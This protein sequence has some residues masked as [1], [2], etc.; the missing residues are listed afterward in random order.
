MGV[1]PSYFTSPTA[2]PHAALPQ[3]FLAPL[4]YKIGLF[5]VIPIKVRLFRF[6]RGGRVPQLFHTAHRFASRAPRAPPQ[7]FLAPI[8][9]RV[10]AHQSLAVVKATS[11]L[12]LSLTLILLSLCVCRPNIV[13]SCDLCRSF[14][15]V[16][17]TVDFADLILVSCCCESI[18]SRGL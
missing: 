5:Y 1:Y 10:R 8:P 13:V 18:V 11:L 6:D 17:V 12:L 3:F 2:L 15:I 14:V 9:L 7:F 16:T 4:C